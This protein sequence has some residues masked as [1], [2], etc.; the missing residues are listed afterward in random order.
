MAKLQAL[1]NTGYISVPLPLEMFDYLQASAVI[2]A[3]FFF[4]VT[5]GFS[6]GLVAWLGLFFLNRFQCSRPVRLGWTVVVAGLFSYLVGFSVIAFLIFFVYFGWAHL[7]INVRYPR[8]RPLALVCLIPFALVPCLYDVDDL[9]L[10]RDHLLR[11]HLGRGLVNFYYHYSPL[12]AEMI[13]P[14]RE[15]VQVTAWVGSEP[16]KV[17]RSWLLRRGVYMLETQEG[18]DA[19]IP[20]DVKTG[21]R[22]LEAVREVAAG[23]GVERLR[24]TI[25]YS[26][27]LATPLMGILF[28]VL[29]TDR[30]L[31]FSHYFIVVLLVGTGVVSLFLVYGTLS[32]ERS[33]LTYMLKAMNLEQAEWDH[34]TARGT[35]KQETKEKLLTLLRSTDP[36]LRMQAV[37]ALGQLPSKENIE[38]LKDMVIHEPIPIVRCKAILALSYQRDRRIVPF[39]ESRLK[40]K[41]AWYVKHYLLRALRRLGWIG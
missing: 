31:A 32:W 11:H 23:R 15:R 17:V 39:L 3:A 6:L 5:L 30:F 33:E 10:V 38:A 25:Y 28:F 9:L 29:L 16:G 14:P 24:V 22:I 41:E 7:F 35:E 20:P 2:K 27:F 21:P 19:V 34:L 18:A 26:I 4:A 37:M 1:V 40:G 36:T 13:T 12:P 8:F